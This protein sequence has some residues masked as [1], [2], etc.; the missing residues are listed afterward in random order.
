VCIELAALLL[1]ELAI[2]AAAGIVIVAG[3]VAFLLYR[4]LLMGAT[5]RLNLTVNKIM[6]CVQLAQHHVT[7]VV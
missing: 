1:L 4:I 5:R 7:S 2:T 3:C 6:V